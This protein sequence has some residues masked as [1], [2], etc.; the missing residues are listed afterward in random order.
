M[1][2]LTKVEA[3]SLV[4]GDLER[5]VVHSVVVLKAVDLVKVKAVRVGRAE[6]AKVVT[7]PKKSITASL[8]L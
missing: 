8:L 7:K 2:S 1:V 3:V 6:M 5:V 4:A